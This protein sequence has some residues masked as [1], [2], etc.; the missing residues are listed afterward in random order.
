M[1]SC[2]SVMLV[3]IL[4]DK[5]STIS[6]YETLTVGKKKKKKQQVKYK[7]GYLFNNNKYIYKNYNKK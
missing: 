7:L 5:V 4:L 6:L 1:G 3:K 2:I